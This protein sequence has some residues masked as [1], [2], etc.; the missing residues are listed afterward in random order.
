MGKKKVVLDTNI[1]ISALGW[2]GKPKEIFRK[3]LNSEFELIIS[4][5][6]LDELRRVINYPKFDFTYQQ[7]ARFL[8]IILEVAKVIEVSGNLDVI[9]E[10]P[11]DNII[12]ETAVDAGADF[13]VSGDEH[14]LKLAEYTNV[15]IVSAAD[16]LTHI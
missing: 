13:I 1:L 10:D 14:L 3:A 11:D 8:A 7:K 4:N 9:S 15:K 2:E 5:Q 12:L 6:Q 16:F